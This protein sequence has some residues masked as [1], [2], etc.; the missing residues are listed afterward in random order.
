VCVNCL[1][2]STLPIPKAS[3]GEMPVFVTLDMGPPSEGGR[4]F[5][6]K[7]LPTRTKRG[8]E[9][10]HTE[11]CTGRVI[12]SK[13]LDEHGNIMVGPKP[14]GFGLIGETQL[15]DIG[16]ESLGDLIASHNYCL[17]STSESFYGMYSSPGKQPCWAWHWVCKE[18][19][20]MA[21]LA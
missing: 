1:C 9:P 7:S 6:I 3:A 16:A 2:R 10:V 8:E 14:E 12:K 18:Q 4:T 5:S 17:H 20:L 15:K 11:H 21:L 13:L 19:G